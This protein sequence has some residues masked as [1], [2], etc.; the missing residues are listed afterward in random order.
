[1][2]NG[3]VG[4]VLVDE[5]LVVEVDVPLDGLGPGLPLCPAELQA[6]GK[7]EV[8]LAVVQRHERIGRVE[9]REVVLIRQLRVGVDEVAVGTGLVEIV[10]Q[11]GEIGV[12]APV[13]GRRRQ[14]AT[15]SQLNRATPVPP[16]TYA[17][18]SAT[19]GPLSKYA[20]ATPHVPRRSPVA[21]SSVANWV[22]RRSVGT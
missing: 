8:G 14:R 9:T 13:S 1:M 10:V 17:A 19:A 21:G 5:A 4:P 2:R 16:L 6:P 12:H 15:A 22:S 20:S 11:S 18:P 7:E 3:V